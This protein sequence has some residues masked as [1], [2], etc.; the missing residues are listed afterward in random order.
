MS[1]TSPAPG[2]LSF[3]FSTPSTQNKET[4]SPRSVAVRPPTLAELRK[5][6]ATILPGFLF[7]FSTRK[8][9]GPIA[10]SFLSPCYPVCLVHVNKEK[11]LCCLVRILIDFAGSWTFLRFLRLFSRPRTRTF[12]NTTRTPSLISF[13]S[14][15]L[16]ISLSTKYKKHDLVF[17][18][19]S[20]PTFR[21]MLINWPC[22]STILRNNSAGQ[23]IEQFH[24]R[25][26]YKK[27]LHNT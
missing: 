18:L 7:S 17:T 23:T 2:S 24:P 9:E 20:Y 11:L 25:L 15:S 1:V 14:L 16:Y 5:I 19:F 26:F 22:R 12:S 21:T 6:F 8:S 4:V 27:V 13:F 3:S 10:P